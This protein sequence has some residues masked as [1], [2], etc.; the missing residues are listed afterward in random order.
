MHDSLPALSRYLKK[1]L[2]EH[3]K[4]LALQ[5]IKFPGFLFVGAGLVLLLRD[6]SKRRFVFIGI[7]FLGYLGYGLVFY[8][9]RYHYFLFPCLFLL[10]CYFLFQKY[11][12]T[13]L[14]CVPV[15]KIPVSWL[16]IIT[17]A[18]SASFRA[19]RQ[20]RG[21][22][23]DE[24]RHLIEMAEFVKSRSSPNEIIIARKP[25]LPYLSGLK[26]AFP[27]LHTSDEYLEKAREMGARYLLYTEREAALWTPLNSFSDPNAIPEGFELIYR[28][29]STNS[30]LY[31]IDSENF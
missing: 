15:L 18:G 1:V 20:T 26:R 3:P 6:L 19:Y 27:E 30:L 21:I 2:Y 8:K 13:V 24:P 11:V 10:P 7:C 28:H 31:E 16:I 5:A 23:D 9:L 25:H 17:L 22:L 29:V 14:G 12:F 4:E